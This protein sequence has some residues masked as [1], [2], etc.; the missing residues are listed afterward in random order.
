M[1]KTLFVLI[2]KGRSSC[3]EDLECQQLVKYLSN[4]FTAFHG[5]RLEKVQIW[6][7]DLPGSS[8]LFCNPTSPTAT[9]KF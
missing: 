9:E 2:G 5:L 1:S 7:E 3:S 6:H 4:L 8:S